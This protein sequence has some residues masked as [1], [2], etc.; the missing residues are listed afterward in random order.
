MMQLLK[1]ALPE[2]NIVLYSDYQTKKLVRSLGFPV[3]KIDC[4]ESGCMLYWV[5]MNTLYHVHFVDMI[6]TSIALPL[7][8]V[9]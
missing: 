1:E 2:D 7:V 9:N 5:M 4:C 8:R 3:E 6:D